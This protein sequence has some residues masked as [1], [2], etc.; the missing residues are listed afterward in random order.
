[1][2]HEMTILA[3]AATIVSSVASILG[4]WAA[5]RGSRRD[6]KLIQ[7]QRE[8]VRYYIERN[9]DLRTA[10]EDDP[11]YRAASP[12]EEA[13]AF[14]RLAI[15]ATNVVGTHR[16]DRKS[17]QIPR[18]KRKPRSRPDVPSWAL[19]LMAD[20]DAQR[21]AWEWGAH[22]HQLIEEGE[23]RQARRDRRRFVVAAVTLAV[24]LRLRRAVGR[25]R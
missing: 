4:A 25:A 9:P 11:K 15:E 12:A 6:R 3:A 16:R 19:G 7:H 24:A 1:M 10:V 2:E 13:E 5:M 8:S 18:L 17:M 22:L 14:A 23:A 20:Q 21:Y